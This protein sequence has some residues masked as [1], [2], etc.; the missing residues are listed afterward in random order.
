MILQFRFLAI[1]PMSINP[2]KQLFHSVT[3]YES[4]SLET[5]HP[6]MQPHYSTQ[7]VPWDRHK[8]TL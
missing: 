4:I 1:Q 8:N 7:N 5:R 2:I 3:Q 6:I